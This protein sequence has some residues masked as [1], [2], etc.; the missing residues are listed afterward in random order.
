MRTNKIHWLND[1]FQGCDWPIL[2][3]LA[4]SLIRL[5]N[6]KSA[7]FMLQFWPREKLAHQKIVGFI[8]LGFINYG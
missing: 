8:D 7:R 6:S 2:A 1:K 5:R 3:N 4:N